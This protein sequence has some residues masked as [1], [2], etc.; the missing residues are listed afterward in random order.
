[1]NALSI[2]VITSMLLMYTPAGAEN[3]T[4]LVFAG[5]ASKPQPQ[6]RPRFLQTRRASRLVYYLAVRATC[7]PK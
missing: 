2:A 1:M 5:A 3:K 7:F 4:L 6:K